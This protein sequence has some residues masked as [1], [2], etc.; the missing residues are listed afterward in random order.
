MAKV[1]KNA[2]ANQYK[3]DIITFRMSSLFVLA[4][5]AIVGIFRLTNGK[6]MLAFYRLV[7]TPGYII[8]A[9]VLLAASIGYVIFN[10]VNKKDESMRSYASLNFLSVVLYGIGVSFYC[11]WMNNPNPWVLIVATIGLTLLYMVYHI[12]ERD[13]F[14]FTL[15]NLVFLTTIWIFSIGSVFKAVVSGALVVLC[16]LCCVYA[17]KQSKKAPRG[18]KLRFEPVYISFLIAVVLLV[19]EI[20]GGIRSAVSAAGLGASIGEAFV[21][22]VLFFQYLAGGIYYTIKL[23][24]EA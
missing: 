2:P 17:Y 15:S 24:K 18:V 21:Y 9:A 4:C 14:I 13:F 3:E 23:I 22:G 11:G 5:A 20:V 6:N 19:L 16:A 1:K 7:R 12:Y 10:K 8:A